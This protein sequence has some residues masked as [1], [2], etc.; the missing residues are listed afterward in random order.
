LHQA[1]PARYKRFAS[2][3]RQRVGSSKKI[4]LP[5]RD[6]PVDASIRSAVGF[7]EVSQGR[8]CATGLTK[9]L[10]LTDRSIIN[11]VPALGRQGRSYLIRLPAPN[12]SI[13]TSFRR[14]LWPSSIADIRCCYSQ[15]LLPSRRRLPSGRRPPPTAPQLRTLRASQ[16]TMAGWF[17]SA[18][19]ALDEQIERATSSSLY[20]PRLCTDAY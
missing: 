20:V 6:A 1:A 4:N 9:Q 8:A 7:G 2:D 10:W 3:S 11:K 14:L 19:S 15:S 13:I 17:G 16:I 12:L 18:N 5:Y